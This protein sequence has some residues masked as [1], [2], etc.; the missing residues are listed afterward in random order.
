MCV[1]T[2]SDDAHFDSAIDDMHNP[3]EHEVHDKGKS[4]CIN[5]LISITSTKLTQPSIIK[6]AHERN[7][8][9]GLFKLLHSQSL[10]NS[11]LE[12]S[13]N[14][15]ARTTHFEMTAKEFSIFTGLELAMLLHKCDN[16]KDYWSTKL[17]VGDTSFSEYQSR[18]RHL[19]M[20]CNIKLQ[21][22]FDDAT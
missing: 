2:D 1:T 13:N 11:I 17:F 12:W 8:E 3:L 21:S 14:A 19:K 22:N 9:V 16:V 18:N 20:R 15:N 10:Q 4:D 7:G 6:S 5:N